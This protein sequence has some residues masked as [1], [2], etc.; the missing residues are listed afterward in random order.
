MREDLFEILD[1]LYSNKGYLEKYSI[2]VIISFFI[3]LFLLIGS[4]YFYVMSI[5]PL[6][7]KDWPINQCNPLYMPFAGLIK[8]D[9]N[10]TVLEATEE[11]YNN[12]IKNIQDQ[13][14]N[15]AL[16]PSY[17]VS[18]I[19]SNILS[20]TINSLDALRN[21]F[22]NIR[23]SVTELNNDIHSRILN[24]IMPLTKETINAQDTIS[25][26]SAILSTSLYQGVGS[27]IAGFSFG[28]A[29]NN[30]L[31]GFLIIMAAAIAAMWVIAIFFFPAAIPAGIA[32]AGYVALLIPF[33][34]V[35]MLL[36]IIF[37]Y[38]G[39]TPPPAP[40]NSCFDSDTLIEMND[41]TLKKIKD[42]KPGDYLLN[43]NKVISKIKSLIGKNK[44]YNF[45][46]ILVTGCHGILT[47]NKWINIENHNDSI[48]INNYNKDFVYCLN[49]EK[50]IIEISGY[51]FMDWDELNNNEILKL[52][53]FTNNNIEKISNKGYDSEIY[54]TKND[55]EIK[56]K[57]LEL[58]DNLGDNN[59]VISIVELYNSE[60]N[61]KRLNIKTSK[62]YF[63]IKKDKIYDY[64]YL[65]KNLLSK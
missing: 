35:I 25:K 62:G 50:K 57:D 10:Q 30:A 42:I 44:I 54:I 37:K 52:N 11:N 58:N 36:S 16:Q 46:N 12:C 6:L 20:E 56:L 29:F 24:I 21:V 15:D 59:I 61:K 51:T 53:K 22:N 41:N 9:E 13:I 48:M 27:G 33:I 23:S 2:D 34:L 4:L 43:N 65:I 47:H 28:V 60:S 31:Q 40:T 64:D 19:Y 7:Q 18:S 55:R 49:T 63:Y 17:Y 14:V 32:T 3:I 8:K 26:I 45:N 39:G 38:N 1:K 5:K